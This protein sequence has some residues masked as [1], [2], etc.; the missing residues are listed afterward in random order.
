[1]SGLFYEHKNMATD[2]DVQFFSHLNG[3]NLGNNWGDLI[4]MLDSTLVT[5]I[6]FSQITNAS[7]SVNGDVHI[8]LFSQHNA[9]LFQVVELSGFAPSS[10]NQRYRIKG[11]PNKTQLILKPSLEI[12]ERS[13]TITGA[14]KLASL[15]YEIV[16][17]DSN[18]V[19]RVYRAKNPAAQHPYIRVD[20]TI[21]DGVNSY[22]SS[23]AKSA[24]VGLIENMTHIDD[25]LDPNKLQLPLDITDF[26]KNWKITGTGATVTRGWSKWYWS[27]PTDSSLVAL[28]ESVEPGSG[29]RSFTVVGNKDAFYFLNS[30]GTTGYYKLIQGAGLI[31]SSLQSVQPSWFL[32]TTPWR[33]TA[34]T[35]KP[36]NGETAGTSLTGNTDSSKVL[37][38]SAITANSVSNHAYCSP[39]LPS[40][41]SGID[42]TFNGGAVGALE[43][44]IYD[45]SSLLRGT[46]P[47]V[48]YSG[49]SHGI[50]TATTSIAAENSMFAYDALTPNGNGGGGGIYFYLGEI[51]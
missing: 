4:R 5:G 22:N 36:I 24:M 10:L 32:M 8:T 23:Y 48:A 17:R 51:E 9:M 45:N 43:I 1:M 50:I 41:T 13:I 30:R 14:G 33:F 39:I 28:Y 42:Q 2:V 12:F 18:D 6:D 25:Y 20:E 15:G 3:L 16:F 38:T 44:P 21:S 49:K 46:L 35:S 7:I 47:I 34:S 26:A 19:K 11:V 27:T 40:Y 31:K 29:N 37:S